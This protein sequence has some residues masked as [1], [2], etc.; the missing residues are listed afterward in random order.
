M[1]SNKINN[2]KIQKNKKNTTEK[3]EIKIL[4]LSDMV[5]LT[6]TLIWREREKYNEIIREKESITEILELVT[7]LGRERDLNI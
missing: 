6:L 3:G 4:L 5:T 2:A 1:N 7:G